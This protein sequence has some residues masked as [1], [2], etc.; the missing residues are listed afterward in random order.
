MTIYRATGRAALFLGVLVL[1]SPLYAEE[2]IPPS[3]WTPQEQKFVEEMRTAYQ[4]QNLPFTE[5]QAGIA[6]KSMREKMARFA[7]Q[8]AG[9]R[10]GLSGMPAMA[11]GVSGNGAQPAQAL[12]TASE[13][14]MGARYAQI[15][16]KSGDV[17]IE[18]RSDGFVVNG[19]PFLDPEGTITDYAFDVVSGN[20]GYVVEG[21]AG[22][23]IKLTRVG[24]TTEPLTLATARESVGGWQV[25]TATGK[26]MSGS[27]Y[28][29]TP[30][31]VLVA[32]ATAAFL[33]EPGKPVASFALPKGYVLA[34]HQ[35]GDVASTGYVLIERDASQASEERGLSSLK[36]LINPFAKKEDYA[37]FGLSSGKVYPLDI[38][39]NA[40]NVRVGS[41]CQRMNAVMNKCATSTRFESLYQPNGLR[42]EGHYY[43]RVV[44]MNT[45]NGPLAAALENDLA[46]L[47]LIELDTGKKV[48]AFTRKMGIGG[49]D[50]K[51]VG[52][53]TVNVSARLGLTKK[54]EI[55]DAM[56][57]VRA[58]GSASQAS[59]A[60]APN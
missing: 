50:A 23:I 28:S 40:K 33:Y 54:E 27:T 10:A 15:P 24:A 8:M 14:E 31:G 13:E 34:T 2:G 17:E 35:R 58:G 32:R 11:G 44:W 46:D 29:V 43:W 12:P 45:P 52:D 51:Q 47:N 57:F 37:L 20:I 53:G 5:E 22:E 3:E 9:I 4:K 1:I 42:N 60:E 16:P 49:F 19:R 56:A 18:G 38:P 39:A 6:V 59:T 25:V 21:A 48:T 41:N 26:T 55:K 30:T 36:S 7:G